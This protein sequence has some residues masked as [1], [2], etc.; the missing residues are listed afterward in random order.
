MP[1]ILTPF[2]QPLLLASVLAGS[3]VLSY[4]QDTT[5]V[6]AKPAVKKPATV[7]LSPIMPTTCSLWIKGTPS[8]EV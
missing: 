7:W 4:G 1:K 3:I 6:P 2:T 8:Q 5:T